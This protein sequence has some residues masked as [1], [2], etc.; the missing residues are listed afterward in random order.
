VEILNRN[1]NRW[2]DTGGFAAVVC[3]QLRMRVF[4]FLNLATADSYLKK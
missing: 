4:A 1:L 2:W 3:S